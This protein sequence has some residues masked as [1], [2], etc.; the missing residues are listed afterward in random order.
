MRPVLALSFACA[1][2]A[3]GG[4]PAKPGQ[5]R[6]E[7]G[8]A[9]SLESPCEKGVCVVG[10]CRDPKDLPVDAAARRFLV[11]PSDL[12]FYT[13]GPSSTDGDRALAG[14]KPKEERIGT[15]GEDELL[16]P[17][18]P[19]WSAPPLPESFSFGRRGL[20]SATLF[21]RFQIPWRSARVLSAY[22]LIEPLPGAPPNER[23]VSFEVSRILEGWS[24]ESVSGM[25]QPR[26]SLPL[27]DAKL[28]ATG[29]GTL[30]IDVTR[31]VEGW[32]TDK[33]DEEGLALSASGDDPHGI[34]TAL[35]VAHGAPPRLEVYVR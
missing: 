32:S 35:G 16:G 8:P 28:R 18:L 13:S 2:A 20:G 6:R 15:R 1:L 25:R 17:S 34:T 14:A 4:A 19:G 10:R 27:V 5:A 3:C 7:P 31:I 9:C 33:P 30:R 29:P 23:P 21:L 12:A 11:D 24:S 26:T 22:L